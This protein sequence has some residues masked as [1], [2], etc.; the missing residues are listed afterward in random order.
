VC[1]HQTGGALCVRYDNFGHVLATGGGDC[2]IKIWD[3]ASGKELFKFKEFVKPVTCLDFNLEGN[4]L[5]AGSVD[6]TV[7]VL[8]LKTQRARASLT[9]HQDTVN[10]LS[11]L[12]RLPRI[13]S[14]SSDR[15]LK[16]WDYDKAQI[17]STVSRSIRETRRRTIPRGP[18]H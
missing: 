13:V 15:T 6:K 17:V 1:A 16:L 3:P 5:C 8:D 11:V 14:A 2:L 4:L 10:S 9:G 7:R 12:L 18:L